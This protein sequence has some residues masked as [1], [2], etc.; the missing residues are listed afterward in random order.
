MTAAASSAATLPIHS[1]EVCPYGESCRSCWSPRIPQ[2]KPLGRPAKKTRAL[3][4]CARCGGKRTEA[5]MRGY[6][7]GLGSAEPLCLACKQRGASGIPRF[8]SRAYRQSI[9]VTA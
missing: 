7:R 4:P 5:N 1:T 6:V 9:G 3:K 2:S 8:F